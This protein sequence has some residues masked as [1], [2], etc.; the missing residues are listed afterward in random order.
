VEVHGDWKKLTKV[1]NRLENVD[2]AKLH[3]NIGEV[4]ISTTHERFRNG[5]APNGSKWKRGLKGTGQ[6]LVQS[7]LLRNS[8]T[9]RFSREGVEVGTNIKYARIHQKGG[10]IRAKKAKFLRFKVGSRWAMKKSVKI[11]ARPFIGISAD[12]KQEIMR[13][14]RETI[15]EAMK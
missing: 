9:K 11:P 2:F 15:S 5:R 8:V 14:F 3:E 13:L 12:D 7:R 1:L 4:L 6:T 10:T